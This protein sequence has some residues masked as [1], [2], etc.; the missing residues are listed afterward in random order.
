M[1]E[2]A[3][4]L[5][6][7][8]NPGGRFAFT[9]FDPHYTPPGLD[10][11]NLEY[12]FEM[13]APDLSNAAI[14]AQVA[15]VRGA[16][17]C[18]LA[19]GE[20]QIESERLENVRGNSAGGYLAFYTP[21]YFQS[22]FPRGEIRTPVAPFPRQHCCIITKGKSDGERSCRRADRDVRAGRFCGS[23]S[24]NVDRRGAPGACGIRRVGNFTRASSGICGDD[25][26][27]FP[28]GVRSVNAIRNS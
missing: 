22:L 18:A 24:D 3:R 1:R 21:E 25:A 5:D 9:F 23:D 20:L 6:Q 26:S 15:R 19:N 7:L 11:N 8:L 10:A 12:Y 14:D 28:L 2:L 17:W 27:V 4:N 16:R 13:R